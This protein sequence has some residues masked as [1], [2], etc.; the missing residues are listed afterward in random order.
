[1][2]LRNYFNFLNDLTIYLFDKL[3][4]FYLKSSYYNKKISKTDNKILEY[5]PSP[6]LLGSLI[7]YE[8]KKQNR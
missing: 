1:M 7:K 2:V 6:S 4:K 3:R 8:K 5:K